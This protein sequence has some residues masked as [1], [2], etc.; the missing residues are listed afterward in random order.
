MK[1]LTALAAL[2]SGILLY[3]LIVY[4]SGYLAA[5]TFP[6]GYSAWFGKSHVILELVIWDLF[7]MSLPKFLIAL[8]WSVCTLLVFRKHYWLICSFCLFGCILTQ[9]YWDFQLDFAVDCLAIITGEPW[10]IPNLASVPC[11]I[12]FAGFLV[13][14][15]RHVDRPIR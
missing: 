1:V 15:F 9:G 3:S 5:V 8:V 11:G 14:K 2:I 6:D 7:V 12:F 4:V 10:A 13:F